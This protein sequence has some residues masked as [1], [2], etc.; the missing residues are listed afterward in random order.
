MATKEF[1]VAKTI[2]P[3]TSTAS[4][5]IDLSAYV[6][7][8]DNQGVEIVHVDYIWHNDNTKLPFSSSSDFQAAVQLKDNTAGGM[9]DYDDI[10]LVSSAGYSNDANV[11][12]QYPGDIY[13]DTLPGMGR[14]VVNDQL[15]IVGDVSSTQT[16]L[17]CTV[18]VTMRIKKLAKRDWMQIA[19]Q[20]VADN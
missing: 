11:G 17:A 10:H 13:P 7:P 4:E 18:R 15:E 16:N 2:L 8:G 5:E 12:G 1:T 9:I 19:L 20:T 3:T 6:D 14:V